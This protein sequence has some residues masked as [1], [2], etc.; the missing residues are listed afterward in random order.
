MKEIDVEED[1]HFKN[2]YPEYIQEEPDRHSEEQYEMV[3]EDKVQE[4]SDLLYNHPESFLEI[5]EEIRAEDKE[6][7]FDFA[8]V[9]MDNLKELPSSLE[10]TNVIRSHSLIL[11]IAKAYEALID[12]YAETLTKEELGG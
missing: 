11:K 12:A 4:A 5:L 9:L 1:E 3:F 10:E 8:K 2:K 7:E 6:Q